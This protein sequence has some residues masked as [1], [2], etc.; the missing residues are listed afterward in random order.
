MKHKLIAS[1]L[2]ASS[3]LFITGCDG[4]KGSAD[5]GS[6][7]SGSAGGGSSGGGSS[8]GTVGGVPL[9]IK[10]PPELIEGTPKAMKV[11]NLV[12]VPEKAPTFLV[13]KEAV[14]LS[15][16]KKVTGSDDN[17]II[18]TLDLITDG[19]K[20]AGEGYFV[21]LIEGPQW[22]QID[23]EKSAAIN[24]I[25]VW[26]YHSQKRAYKGV[27]I[28]ISDDPTFKTGATTVYN[29]DYENVCEMGKGPDYPYV[30]SRFGL[31]ADGKGTKGRYV[32][33]YSNGNTSNDMNHYIEV[34]VYG[35]PQ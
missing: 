34:E 35:V 2:A 7:G 25:W 29:N 12:Q 21:E 32:R 15:K 11:P 4:K 26:H 31:I 3:A 1:I 10:F 19:D 33:L 23:L 22:V 28:R 18:G 14:L 27:I 30:E 13:P 8:G 17:P 24:A 16:D 5:S 6:A 20:Q 9:A